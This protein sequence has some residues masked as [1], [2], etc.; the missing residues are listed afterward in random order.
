MIEIGTWTKAKQ[1]ASI[2]NALTN[3]P[4]L[5]E[6]TQSY[7]VLWDGDVSA[8]SGGYYMTENHVVNLSKSISSLH[9]GIVL[10]WQAYDSTNK[11]PFDY[12]HVYNFVPKQHIVSNPGQDN[13]CILAIGN[14]FG[15][16][17]VYI[18]DNSIVGNA[19]NTSTATLNGLTFS[20]NHWI[21]TEVIGI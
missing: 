2:K 16:K 19:Q 6:A 21:L 18:S 8:S 9:K 12:D 7:E 4:T 5:L 17:L 3:Y 15:R 14:N 10:H 1:K 11:T 20:N 13:L